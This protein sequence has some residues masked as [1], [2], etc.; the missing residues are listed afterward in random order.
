M[1]I[2]V[3]LIVGGLAGYLGS[4]IVKG[5]GSGMLSNIFLGLIGSLIGSYV[6]GLMGIEGDSG[7][8]NFVLSVAGA[9][10]I[11]VIVGLVQGRGRD[12]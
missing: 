12:E 6:F 2:L 9:V 3:A 1:N 7:F 8:G 4:K 11:L 10:I 5:K